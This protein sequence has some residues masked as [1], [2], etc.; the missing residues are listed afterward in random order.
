[1]TIV[2]AMTDVF[3]EIGNWV[4]SAIQSMMSIFWTPA[5]EGTGGSLTLL[6][7]LCCVSVAI[8]VIFLVI[9]VI[10]NFIHLRS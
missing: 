2:K 5:A 7:T 1:M 3:T 8:A 10:Q 6:G 4:V 9:G